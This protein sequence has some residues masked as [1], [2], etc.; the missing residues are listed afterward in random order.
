MFASNS[1]VELFTWKVATATAYR[2]RASARAILTAAIGEDGTKVTA[3]STLAPLF[4]SSAPLQPSLQLCQTRRSYAA[5]TTTWEEGSDLTRLGSNVTQTKVDAN[6][7]YEAYMQ[8]NFPE[9]MDPSYSPPIPPHK[10][11]RRNI[12]GLSSSAEENKALEEEGIMR[13]DIV[14]PRNIRP[15]ITY[16][17]DAG[18]DTNSRRSEYMRLHH[19]LIPGLL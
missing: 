4:S 2:Q 19:G 5:T 13:K 17:R 3:T 8:A 6:P 10:A 15:L 11:K 14:Y 7:E 12:T 18:R 16:S 1:L 9:A